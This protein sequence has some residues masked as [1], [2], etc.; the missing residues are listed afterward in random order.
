M[1]TS[2][3]VIAVLIGIVAVLVLV[4]ILRKPVQV[5]EKPDETFL[6]KQL[7]QERAKVQ[8]WESQSIYWSNVAGRAIHTSDSLKA[9]PPKIKRIYEDTYKTIRTGT[10]VQLDSVIRSNW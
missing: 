6:Q 8:Y 7:E 10:A 4:L 9:L 5:V 1:K 3:I 2:N